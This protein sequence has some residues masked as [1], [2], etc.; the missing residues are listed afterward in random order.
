MQ[1]D[2]IINCVCNFY[3]INKSDLLG[4]KKNKEFVE[5]RMI[6]I[7]LICDM[8]SVPLVSIGGIFGGRDHATIIHARD[9]ISDLLS[10]N[11]GASQKLKIQINDIK[12]ML[13]K[14]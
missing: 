6:A 1:A 3:K 2:D 4:K 5:P 14:R 8:L 9:K 11:S 12:D 7:Y 13:Y 10:S